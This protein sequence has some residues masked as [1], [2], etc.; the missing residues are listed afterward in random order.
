MLSAQTK[1]GGIGATLPRNRA[2]LA[3][4]YSNSLLSIFL[5]GLIGR[6]RDHPAIIF[7]V[8][9]WLQAITSR[10]SRG[11]AL[12]EAALAIPIILLFIGGAIDLGSLLVRYFPPQS[13]LMKG[14][15]TLLS[16]RI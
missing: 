13:S 9:R 12:I 14:P 11:V 1:R 10:A 5:I 8:P 16:F 15:D 4:Q 2:T 6:M 7:K 3:P